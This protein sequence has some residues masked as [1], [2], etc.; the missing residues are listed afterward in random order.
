MISLK[1]I[2]F[3]L[4]LF[5]CCS[6]TAEAV[7]DT[8]ARLFHAAT[9]GKHIEVEKMNYRIENII[10]ESDLLLV[11][12]LE[13]VNSINYP[14]FIVISSFVSNNN[15]SRSRTIINSLLR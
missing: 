10:K 13:L 7:E 1:K 15:C 5:I 4:L 9:E 14:P 12:L 8:E 3:T 11:L 6:V 2:S